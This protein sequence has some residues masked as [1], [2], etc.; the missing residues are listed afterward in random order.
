M[1]CKIPKLLSNAMIAYILSSIIYLI[2]TL[3]VDT[4]LRNSYTKK[5]KK[6]AKRSGRKRMMIFLVSLVIS[7]IGVLTF[8]PF[9]NCYLD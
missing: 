5:Q 6:I 3:F 1:Y 9:E 8:K 4:P 2:I 7:I